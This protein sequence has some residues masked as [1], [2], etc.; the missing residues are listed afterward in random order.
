MAIVL[1]EQYYD[2]A[3]GLADRYVGMDR[4]RVVA[5]GRGVDMQADRARERMMI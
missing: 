5:S 4:G 3:A 2:F 1:V